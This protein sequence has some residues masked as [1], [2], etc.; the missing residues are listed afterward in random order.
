MTPNVITRMMSAEGFE[1][2]PVRERII[3]A[4]ILIIAVIHLM[5]ISG[6][7]GID[8]LASLYGIA[9]SGGN[10]EIL[11]RHRAVLL[12][13]LGG[14]LVFAAFKPNYQPLA[15]VLAFVSLASFHYLAN[16]VGEYNDAIRRVVVADIAA[17]AALVAAIVLYVIGK[18]S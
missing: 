10:L 15:F 14:F 13:S 3:T 9:I 8:R 12:G 2:S 6:F 1:G 4:L 16:S 11:M 18:K 5:P 17:S 7:F